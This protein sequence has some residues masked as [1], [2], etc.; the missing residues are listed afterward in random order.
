MQNLESYLSK[1]VAKGT[2]IGLLSASGKEA[3]YSR[4]GYK[5]RTGFPLGLGMCKFV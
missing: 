1:V 3:F 2:T 4:H 5:E